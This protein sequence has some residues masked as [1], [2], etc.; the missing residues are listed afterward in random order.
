MVV[1]DVRRL[2][3]AGAARRLVWFVCPLLNL[4]A[5]GLA[6]AELRRTMTRYW[7]LA[8]RPSRQL[9]WLWR[10]AAKSVLRMNGGIFVWRRWR[11]AAAARSAGRLANNGVIE[12]K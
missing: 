9:V 12:E 4:G 10:S 11:V 8:R 1:G 2:T 6:R 5:G 3:D 7:P